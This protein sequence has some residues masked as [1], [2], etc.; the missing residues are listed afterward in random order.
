MLQWGLL[1]ATALVRLRVPRIAS[2]DG[3]SRVTRSPLEDLHVHSS[4][5]DQLPVSLGESDSV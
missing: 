3:T 2:F 1:R 4:A 5:L